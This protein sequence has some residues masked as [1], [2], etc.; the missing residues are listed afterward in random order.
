MISH[1]DLCLTFFGAN[2]F[3]M[4]ETLQPSARVQRTHFDFNDDKQCVGSIA[5]SCMH[6]TT[7]ARHEVG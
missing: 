2:W 7:S 4:F 6:G 3:K 5:I 1:G